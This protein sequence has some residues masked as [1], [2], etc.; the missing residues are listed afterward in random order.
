M[1]LN[2]DSCIFHSLTCQIIDREIIWNIDRIDRNRKK[3][4]NRV[5]EMIRQLVFTT[6]TNSWNKFQI[7]IAR[8]AYFA[9]ACLFINTL[10]VSV[11]LQTV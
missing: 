5:T 3:Y 10:I 11:A 1:L 9:T 8:I 7:N 4:R 2:P 6:L